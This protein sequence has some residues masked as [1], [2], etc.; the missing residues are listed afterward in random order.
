MKQLIS[1]FFSVLEGWEVDNEEW[2]WT[3]RK[4]KIL[5]PV[6]L[7]SS[8]SLSISPLLSSSHDHCYYGFQHEILLHYSL[9]CVLLIVWS[10]PLIDPLFSH[11]MIEQEK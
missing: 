9:L 5:L 6:S 7:L 1:L 2:G 11:K 10:Y 3:V 8:S 4:I